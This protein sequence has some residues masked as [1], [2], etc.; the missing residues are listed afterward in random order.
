VCVLSHTSNSLR[1]LE[2]LAVARRFAV[3]SLTWY[4]FGKKF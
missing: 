4:F 3:A 1:E 2:K